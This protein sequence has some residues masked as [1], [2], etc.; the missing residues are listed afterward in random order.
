MRE[1]MLR[2]QVRTLAKL[3]TTFSAR[4]TKELQIETSPR[5]SSLQRHKRRQSKDTGRNQDLSGEGGLLELVEILRG[6]WSGRE[7]PIRFRCNGT[8]CRC[9]R[10]SSY[11]NFVG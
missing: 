11:A 8:D 4:E 6:V 7:A 5:R 2:T 1:S 9:R 10:L 3:S